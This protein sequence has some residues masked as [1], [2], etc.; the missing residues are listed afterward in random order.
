[1][2]SANRPIVIS[3]AWPN[4]LAEFVRG[5]S[6]ELLVMSP[7]ITTVAAK[8]IAN[9]LA[10]SGPVRLQ[11]LARLDVADFLSGSSHIA[12]FLGGN[13]SV[14]DRSAIASIAN[15][16]R[17]NGHWRPMQSNRWIGEHDRERAM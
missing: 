14:G 16:A 5:V 9:N 10:H 8:L 6:N 11:L 3:G 4:I 17:K 2:T 7:W 12:A 15:V 13:V 1:M